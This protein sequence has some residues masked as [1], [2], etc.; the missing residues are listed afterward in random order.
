MADTKPVVGILSIGEMGLGIANLLVNHGYQVVTFAEDRRE[1]TRERAKS[2]NISLLPSI[3]DLVT[4]STVILSIVPPKDSFDTAKRIHEATPT[5]QR[6]SPLYY[7]DLNATSPSL[8]KETSALLSSNKNIVYIDGG[9]IGGPPSMLS[10]STGT[11]G[12]WNKPSL[13]TSGPEKLPSTPVYEDLASTLNIEHISDR[14]GSASGTKLCFAS[15]TKGFF[16]IAI[17]AFVTAEKMGVFEDFRRYMQRHNSATLN[18]AEKGV[19]GM[20][21]KAWRWVGEMRMIGECMAE[22]G[23]FGSG[24]FDEVAE[25]YRVVAEDTALGQEQVE[26]RQRGKTVDDVVSVMCE[27]MDATRKKKK[28][29]AE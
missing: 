6:D 4:Q 20:P 15:T 1:R 16:A 8:A 21:S 17:Q 26:N 12:N 9:I 24:L 28:E 2:I 19:V 23:G 27:G 10:D 3:A 29:K 11:T 14:I 22:E 18:I 25:V 5:E 13:V 7:L